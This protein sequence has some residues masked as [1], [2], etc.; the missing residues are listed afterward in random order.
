VEIAGQPL[1]LS[2]KSKNERPVNLLSPSAPDGAHSTY[3]LMRIEEL[4][5]A[6]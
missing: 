4:I 1:K 3:R 6:A 5:K 2:S